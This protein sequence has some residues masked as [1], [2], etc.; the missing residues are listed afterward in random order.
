MQTQKSVM[1][2]KLIAPCGMNCGLCAAYLR[3][4]NRCPGCKGDNTNKPAGCVKC[5]IKN[6]QHFQNGK[7]KYC[8]DCDKL[9]CLRLKQ[10]DKR[11]R[12]KYHMSMIENLEN[13]KTLGIRKFVQ[14]EKLRWTCAEC[15]GTI[16]VH[17]GCCYNCG[18]A[19]NNR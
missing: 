18:K 14:N 17:K 12:T 5:I 4:K 9:P 10:L 2:S 13:I 16:C 3:Q 1:N 6:C 19:I 15:G 11:Y 7:S 8:F